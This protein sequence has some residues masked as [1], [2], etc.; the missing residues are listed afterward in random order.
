M[1]LLHRYWIE[2]DREPPYNRVGVTA[3]TCEDALD[4]LRE[5]VFKDDPLPHVLSVIGEV[6]ITTLDQNHFVINMGVCSRRGVWYPNLGS[7]K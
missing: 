7:S 1:N 4:L 5:N 3:Y 2:L 6:D